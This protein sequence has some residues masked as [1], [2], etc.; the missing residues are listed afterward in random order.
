MYKYRRC[1]FH[2]NHSATGELSRDEMLKSF[3]QFGVKDIGQLE[4]DNVLACVDIDAGGSIGFDEFLMVTIDPVECMTKDAIFTMF[5]FF[6]E[7]GGG[8]ISCG[9]IKEALSKTHNIPERVW[10][11][12]FNTKPGQ[13]NQL[14]M[15]ISLSE[16]KE[17]MLRI[18][19][20][21]LE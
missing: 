9:E 10:G 2:L 5:R 21:K 16:F 19:S 12:V 4:M 11:V 20:M 3:W 7:D 14:E 1:F 18:F 8:S 17:F 15:E 6:D 13:E